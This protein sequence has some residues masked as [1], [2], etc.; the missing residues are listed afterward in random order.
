MSENK[1]LL[2]IVTPTFN[3]E[4]NIDELYRQ[5]KDV[6]TKIPKYN[7]EFIVID[8][9]SSDGTVRKLKA[10]AEKDSSLKIIINERNFGHIRSPYHGILQSKGSATIYLAS[11][12]QDPPE[13][14][15]Q[16]I[17]YWEKGYKLV[18]GVKP[19][20][21][22]SPILHFVRKFYYRLLRIISNVEILNDATG[23]GIYDKKVLD[24][25]RSLNEPYPFLRGLLSELGYE[26]KKIPF[27]Q[28]A[29]FK[30]V[31]KNNFYTL[32][33]IAILGIVNHSK[34][35]LRF[36]SLLGFLIGLFS[37]ILAFIFLILKLIY[38]EYFPL[39]FAPLFIGIFFMFGTLLFFIGLLG[40]YIISI[41]TYMQ[42]RPLV[43]EKERINF[44]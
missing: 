1:I 24:K 35:P 29:R 44:D 25:L 22:T 15:S 26:V 4:Q 8:N 39:G 31:T 6:I 41:H 38:W 3:E 17:E 30:G 9:H 23:F 5:V 12:L 13:L 7:F 11:D 28:P 20:S 14:I 37:F 19:E 21:K 36:A 2:S 43:V 32:Y 27:V 18:L 16:F 34:T 42:N 40:E 10:L 33:D